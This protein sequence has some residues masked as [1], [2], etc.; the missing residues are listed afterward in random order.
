[1]K[2]GRFVLTSVT[3]MPL[4]LRVTAWGTQEACWGLPRLYD[5]THNP[6]KV[7]LSGLHTG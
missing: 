7:C 2:A 5:S 6:V 4:G 3:V 1:M